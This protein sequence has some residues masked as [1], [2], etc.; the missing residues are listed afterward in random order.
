[1][2]GMKLVV[3]GASGATGKQLV[4]QGLARG[5]HVTAFVRTPSK[6]MVK[7]G[8][9]RVV[10]G[11]VAESTSVAHAIAG[12]DAVVIALGVGKPLRHDPAVI[13]G[14]RNIVRAMDGKQSR[15]IY[16]SFLGVHEGRAQLG[17]ILGRIMANIV[18]RNEV[19][20]HEVKEDIVRRSNLE[21]TIV[22]PVGLT[23]GPRT[24]AY[25]H[26]L[27]VRAKSLVPTI[28]RADVADFMLG[29][30]VDGSYVRK[31]VAVMH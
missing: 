26:G 30:L 27:D 8:E 15:L 24:G 12:N 20:D 19:V 21:W 7:H 4:A 29:E 31:A 10:Q 11:D 9:L 14:V 22:R 3:F 16:L 17:F 25:R 6:L 28:S 5:H 1:M 2:I 23:N 13:E 18:V